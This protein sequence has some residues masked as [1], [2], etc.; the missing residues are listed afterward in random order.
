MDVDDDRCAQLEEKLR[1]ARSLLHQTE[2]RA[3]EVGFVLFDVS[4]KIEVDCIVGRQGR[5]LELL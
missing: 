5:V 1:E 2:I 3:D 4:V